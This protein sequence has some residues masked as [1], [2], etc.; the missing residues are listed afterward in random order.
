M[1]I[2]NSKISKQLEFQLQTIATTESCKWHKTEKL[3]GTIPLNVF[4]WLKK[5]F[6]QLLER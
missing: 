2:R 1:E 3:Y 6:A 5:Q 4:N